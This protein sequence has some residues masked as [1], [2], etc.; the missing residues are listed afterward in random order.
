MIHVPDS[1]PVCEELLWIEAEIGSK[2]PQFVKVDTRTMRQD[3]LSVPTTAQPSGLHYFDVDIGRNLVVFS[4][5]TDIFVSE[6]GEN[7]ATLLFGGMS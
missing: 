3:E 4:F 5:N 7:S 2:P 1:P 6:I